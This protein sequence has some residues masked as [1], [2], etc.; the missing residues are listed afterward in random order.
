[1]CD[2]IVEETRIIKI[3]ITDEIFIGIEDGLPTIIINGYAGDKEVQ[4]HLQLSEDTELNKSVM[5]SIGKAITYLRKLLH[6]I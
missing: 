1:M 6:I 5:D 2:D 3:Q 4:V